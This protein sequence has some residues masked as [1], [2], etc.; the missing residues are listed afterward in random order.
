[1]VKAGEDVE[2][3]IA[4]SET[5]AANWAPRLARKPADAKFIPMAATWLN[6][7]RWDDEP[8]GQAPPGAGGESMIDLA[9]EFERRVRDRESEYGQGSSGR[10]EFS[11]IDG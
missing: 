7:G 10:G 3:I 4:A 1:M 2:K 8:E 5:F 6:K 9:N 11:F